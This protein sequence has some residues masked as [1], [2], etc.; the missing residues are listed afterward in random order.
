MK[1]YLVIASLLTA[2]LLPAGT[3]PL[4]Q[5]A[6][7]KHVYVVGGC[8]AD[9][10][11]AVKQFQDFPDSLPF[12]LYVVCREPDWRDFMQKCSLSLGT[13]AMSDW[14]RGIIWLGPK[15]LT[16]SIAMREAIEHELAHLHCRCSLGERPH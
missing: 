13:T 9:A 11:N 7:P 8:R 16:D 6:I 14:K 3:A 10:S 5:S 12:D 2:M 15:A 1:M 4:A